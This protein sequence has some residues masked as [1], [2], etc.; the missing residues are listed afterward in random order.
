[1]RRLPVFFLLDCSESMVGD[2]LRQMQDG[3]AAIVNSLRSDPHALESVH[4]SVIA[5]LVFLV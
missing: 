4:I 2:P 3:L 5:L 1:M